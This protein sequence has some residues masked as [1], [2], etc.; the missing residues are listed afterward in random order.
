MG[1]MVWFGPPL[2]A[3][4]F[5]IPALAVVGFGLAVVGAVAGTAYWAGKQAAK[6]PPYSSEGAPT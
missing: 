5:G 3:S 1:R 2:L 6:Q 4:G